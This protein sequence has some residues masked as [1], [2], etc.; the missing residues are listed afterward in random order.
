MREL[1]G[2]DLTL[3]GEALL[4]AGGHV[5]VKVLLAGAPVENLEKSGDERGEGSGVGSARTLGFEE[6]RGEGRKAPRTR[7]GRRPR[8]R[9]ARRRATAG[10]ERAF[11]TRIEWRSSL[12]RARRR[13]TRRAT[14][15]SLDK[16][17]NPIDDVLSERVGECRKARASTRARVASTHLA[18]GGDLEALGRRLV[19]LGLLPGLA[20][21][22]HHGHGLGRDGRLRGDADGG[23]S[24][25]EAEAGHLGGGGD[26]RSGHGERRHDYSLIG[27]EVRD[28]GLSTAQARV[29][30][31][32]ARAE[33]TPTRDFPPRRHN[34]FPQKFQTDSHMTSTAFTKRREWD[35]SGSISIV[36]GPE[37]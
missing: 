29:P 4:V 7:G 6:I 30:R 3:A 33:G 10:E 12:L 36:G 22:H 18:G 24:L 13:R 31:Y 25:A 14:P 37:R 5:G 1:L 9:R 21:H 26:A 11:W 34:R 35:A 17:L 2:A 8:R 27:V 19:G 23:D 15:R 28:E 32:P 16:T 20:S